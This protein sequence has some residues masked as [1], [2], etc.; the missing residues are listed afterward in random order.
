MRAGALARR[1]APPVPAGPPPL[2]SA[3]LVFMRGRDGNGR[4]RELASARL[5]AGP[6]LGALSVALIDRRAYE[7]LGYRSLGDYG[8]ERLGVGARAVREWAR[9]WGVRWTPA[10]PRRLP[11]ELAAL[12]EGLEGAPPREIDWGLRAAIAFLQTLDLETGRIVHQLADRRR[13]AE[14]G[15]P[16]LARNAAERLVLSACTARR[17]VA[18]ARVEQRTPAVATA[19]RR[20]HIHAFQAQMLARVADLE[21]ARARVERAEHLTVPPPRK[22]RRG[23][24][25]RAGGHCVPGAPP[26][27]RSRRC[28]GRGAAD[29]AADGV[30]VTEQWCGG[31]LVSA[32]RPA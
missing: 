23:R 24:S 20:A 29:G 15:F 7:T 31:R 12:T 22:G 13:F 5:V 1:P 26:S 3:G 4:L 30:R 8:R 16:D 2:S 21:S 25:A 28:R 6:V 27:S 11:A 9:V 10:A 17:L 19:F 32:L 14:L 18:L